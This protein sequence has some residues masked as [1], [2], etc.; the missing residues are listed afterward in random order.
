MGTGN[1]F[2]VMMMYANGHDHTRV[3]INNNKIWQLHVKVIAL[4]LQVYL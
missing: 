1:K 3:Y 4:Q 2:N